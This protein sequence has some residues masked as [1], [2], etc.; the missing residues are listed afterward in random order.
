VFSDRYPALSRPDDKEVHRLVSYLRSVARPDDPIFVEGSSTTMNYDVLKH[1][2]RA[3]QPF[4]PSLSIQTTPQVDS[5]DW[6][7]I[8]G[9]LRARAVVVTLPPQFHLA[10]Q[11]QD[12]VR[13]SHEVFTKSWEFAGDFSLAPERFELEHRVEARVFLRHRDT[14]LARSLRLM[15]EM[16]RWMGSRP[17][18]PAPAWLALTPSA[19]WADGARTA[20]RAVTGPGHGRQAILHTNP[21]WHGDRITLLAHFE[22]SRGP[23]RVTASAVDLGSGDEHVLDSR[24]LMQ[25]AAGPMPVVLNTSA[26]DTSR[27]WLLLSVEALDGA[28]LVVLS[29]IA[30]R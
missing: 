24:I 4:G 2:D 22:G 8:E 21:D 10:P 11:E 29:D 13:L 18:G 6:Y 19:F 30:V 12:V 5:R 14:D 26:A 1:A 15:G 3:S 25:T 20:L 27:G 16:R 7:P 17:L 28:P 23:A 9:L